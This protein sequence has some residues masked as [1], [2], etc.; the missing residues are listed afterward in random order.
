MRQSSFQHANEMSLKSLLRPH[1]PDKLRVWVTGSPS[2]EDMPER[3]GLCLE[4]KAPEHGGCCPLVTALLGPQG[5]ACT[6][7][8]HAVKVYQVPGH[9][10]VKRGS[11]ERATQIQ[12]ADC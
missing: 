9:P 6:C 4:G 12:P 11:P 10:T 3:L 5:H 2:L 8:V 1:S 7:P